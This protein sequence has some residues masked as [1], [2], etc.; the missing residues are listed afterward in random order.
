ML[1]LKGGLVIRSGH[2]ADYIRSNKYRER[3][4]VLSSQL[5]AYGVLGSDLDQPVVEVGQEGDNHLEW[6]ST[7]SYEKKEKKGDRK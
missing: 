3:R 7:V 2:S 5:K 1:D 6:V 4:C